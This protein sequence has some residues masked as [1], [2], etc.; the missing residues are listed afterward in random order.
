MQ[1]FQIKAMKQRA[2]LLRRI[3]FHNF[4]NHPLV[5][6]VTTFLVLFFFSLAVFVSVGGQT[7]GADDTRV[8]RL[9]IDGTQQIVPTRAK[10]VADLVQRLKLQLNEKDIVEPAL[11]TEIVDDNFSV[12]IYKARPVTII[13][14]GKRVTTFTAA[15]TPRAVAESAGVMVYPEDKVEKQAE[16]VEPEDIVRDGPIAERVVIDRATPTTINLY[17]NVIPMRT[18]AQTVGE[19]LREKN[20][21][22]LPGDVITPTPETPLTSAINVF[23]VRVGKKIDTK[24]EEIPM[25]I[26]YVSDPSLTLGT[27]VVKQKGTPGRKIVTYEVELQNDKEISRKPLQEVLAAEP[28]KQVVAKGTKPPVIIVAGDHAS[29]MTA[30]GIPADQ[31][32]SAE[33]IIARESGWRLAARNAGGCL[34][35]GQACPGSKLVNACPDYATNAIC[36]LQFFNGYAVGRYGSWNGA[37]QFWIVNH[38]W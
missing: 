4:K 12:N 1:Q 38:W 11:D 8:V 21:Q 17:G 16:I 13:D 22:T 30:A 37:Y 25:P 20:I 33:Y 26:E 32:G 18:H 28:V 10:T 34:G 29:L 7:I 27:L 31:Q 24:E 5:V 9:S 35:L 14:E 3:R 23:I 6:P 15:A 19:A 36:Q 2:K